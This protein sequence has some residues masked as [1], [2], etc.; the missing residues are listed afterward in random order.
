MRKLLLLLAL[1]PVACS[2]TQKDEEPLLSPEDR[3][4]LQAFVDKKMAELPGQVQLSKAQRESAAPFAQAAA[5]KIFE[6]ARKY[7][8][9]PTPANLK[10]FSREMKKIRD[11]L[12]QDIKPLMTSSQRYTYMSVFD[13]VLQEIRSLD[14]TD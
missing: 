10:R 3:A 8:A 14:L 13:K 2:N 1:F 6:Q 9:K 11:Q 7:H 4:E 12:S 5:R